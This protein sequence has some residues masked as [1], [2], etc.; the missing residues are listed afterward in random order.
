MNAAEYCEAML[1]DYEAEWRPAGLVEIDRPDVVAWMQPGWPIGRNRVAYAKWAAAHVDRRIDEILAFFADAPFMWHVGPSSTPPDLEPRLLAHGLV[2]GER[3]R[4]MTAALPLSG[5]RE[6][7]VR[8]VEVVDRATARVGL[9][10]AH[11]A[12]ADLE[13]DLKERMA[14]LSLPTRRSGWL[15]AFAGDAPVANAGYRFSAD[16]RCLYL[17]GAETIESRRG[18]G[19]YQTLVAY[20]ARLA[21][22]RGC[23]IVSILANRHTSAPILARHG[24]A[25]H[26]E[27][28]WFRRP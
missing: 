15:V 14:Y 10:L 22:E 2:V 9:S 27:L 16:G 4:L 23:E 6:A 17:T 8:I 24:F 21:Y 18:R 20:R 13:R 7:D 11:H 3:P 19:I 1:Y 12:G 5:L 25:D 26:G 28:P